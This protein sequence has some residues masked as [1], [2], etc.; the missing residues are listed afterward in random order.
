MHDQK[1]QSMKQ[2]L[3]PWFLLASALFLCFS[4]LCLPQVLA[5]TAAGAEGK[6]QPFV[7]W[8]M[9]LTGWLMR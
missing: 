8:L 1:N 6:D 7:V 5:A 9:D 2:K 4:G 3:Y